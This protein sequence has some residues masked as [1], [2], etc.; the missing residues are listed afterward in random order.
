MRLIEAIILFVCFSFNGNAQ[1]NFSTNWILGRGNTYKY[2]FSNQSISVYDT[3]YNFYFALG[4]SCISDSQGRLKII[5]NGYDVMDSVGNIIENGD[6]IV[7]KL[8][9]EKYSGF[10]SYS[11]SSIILP[12]D[13]G[14]YYVITPAAS[15]HQIE[16]VWNI[17]NGSKS[18]FDILLYHKLDMNY[19]GGA[20]KVVKKAVPLLENIELSKPQMMACR[21]ANGTDWWLLKQAHDTNMVYRFLVTKDSVYNMGIQGFAEPHFGNQDI[22]GQSMFNQ[23]GTQYATVCMGANELFYA[24]FDRCTGL[25][26]HPK[27]L[28]IANHGFSPSDSTLDIWPAGVCFS[29][30][31]ELLY[32]VKGY[33]IFQLDL[34]NA[35]LSSAWYH[36]ANLDTTWAAFQGW[37]C[38]YL[39]PDNKMYIGN[40]NGL[41]AAMSYIEYPDIIGSGCGFCAKCLRFPKI[42][43][44]N[45]PCMPNYGLGRMTDPCAPEPTD[46][47]IL[48]PNPANDML[49]LSGN[50]FDE[51]QISI[52]DLLGQRVYFKKLRVSTGKIQVDIHGLHAGIYLLRMGKFV[53]KFLKE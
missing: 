11:Q 14:I 49:F 26:S 43:A 1:S 47:L 40:W 25:L 19:N 28:P 42:G 6:T 41:G 23:Q 3:M 20:G 33:N 13:S 16:T 12:F 29:P 2:S 37:S 48:Y 21:H 27:V 22:I 4:A 24:D 50:S 34:N 17:P 44:G 39:G 51:N 45:P 38:A 8:L 52:Y 5:C 31:G 46:E 53:G 32:V 30:S 18:P 7:P 15:N 36:I 35:D 10:S 9:Y